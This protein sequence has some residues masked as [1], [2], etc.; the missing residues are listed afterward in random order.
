MEPIS[1]VIQ[2]LLNLVISDVAPLLK[3]CVSEIVQ[4]IFLYLSTSTTFKLHLH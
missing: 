2:K 3:F 4:I 1:E